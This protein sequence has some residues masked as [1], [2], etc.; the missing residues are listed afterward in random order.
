MMAIGIAVTLVG[1]PAMAGPAPDNLADL[2]YQSADWANEQ[3]ASR[4]YTS[5]HSDW[6]KGHNWSYWWQQSSR[7]C[8]KM[9]DD[10]RKVV[11]LETT[12]AMDCNQQ[13]PVA[14][15]KGMSDGAKVAI[16]AAAIL[17]VALLASKSHHREEKN[18]Q[19]EKN[20]AEFER[21]YRDGLHHERYHNYQNSTSYSDGYNSGQ[22][23]RDERT[24]HRAFGGF[25]SGYQSFV[26]LDD[27]VGARAAGAD[28][29][30]QSRGFRSVGGYQLG[31]RSMA[32]WW[33]GTTRQ[34]V[35]AVTRDGRIER[36]D[37]IAEGN[38]L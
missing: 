18:A 15:D 3:L 21:G 30:L 32:T 36:F 19:N 10:T 2:N 26:S 9:Q 35:Q 37:N 12:V 29:T 11:S 20:T 7:I 5:I 16:G 22:Q 24:R 13:E 28:S 8:I 6:H 27:L 33:N 38:C 31:G 4:G 17:G 25:H 14:R 23:D 34:C 1:R